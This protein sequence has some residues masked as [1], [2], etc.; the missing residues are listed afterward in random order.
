MGYCVHGAKIWL[1]F[2]SQRN[3]FTLCFLGLFPG[4][5]NHQVINPQ[6]WI[7]GSLGPLGFAHIVL[8]WCNCLIQKRE[9]KTWERSW[10][11]RSG[12]PVQFSSVHSVVSDSLQPH[13]SQHARPPCP[14]PTPGVHPN[15]CASSWWC[16][17]AISSSVVSFSSCPQSLPASGSFPMSQLFAWGGQS[18]GVSVSAS[19][20]KPRIWK[21]HVS[22]HDRDGEC[23]HLE[24]REVSDDFQG[25]K[26]PLT[27]FLSFSK[28]EMSKKRS[29]SW[30]NSTWK[31]WVWFLPVAPS[32]GQALAANEQSMGPG[33]QPS[34]GIYECLK[35]VGR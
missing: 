26:T 3:W 20:L 5:H 23:C 2:W 25:R 33:D 4:G 29:P 24:K 8:L 6:T 22:N 14:S 17:P 10:D 30:Q 32:Q 19:V 34:P 27:G 12:S 16:H 13:E 31:K 9:K 15:S 18:T 7:P 1:S 28:I 35:E 21:T 11:Q